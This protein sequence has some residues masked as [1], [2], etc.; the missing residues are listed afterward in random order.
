MANPSRI[1]GLVNIIPDMC[2]KDSLHRMTSTVQELMSDK[3]AESLMDVDHLEYHPILVNTEMCT[4]NSKHG[5]I[6]IPCRQYILYLS[7]IQIKTYIQIFKN[8]VSTRKAEF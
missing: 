4:H 2:F 7:Y 3:L 8:K 6:H 5:R 1:G